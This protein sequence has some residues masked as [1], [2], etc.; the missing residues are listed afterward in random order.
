M[1]AEGHRS[2]VGYRAFCEMEIGACRCL[3]PEQHHQRGPGETVDVGTVL[4]AAMSFAEEI[5]HC[6]QDNSS[7]LDGD[8]VFGF[9]HL[10]VGD[11]SLKCRRRLELRFRTPRT[12][13]VGIIRTCTKI[14]PA[15]CIVKA[16][17]YCVL[18]F[19]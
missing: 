3:H 11:V 13:P 14:C 6:A 18:D 17:S 9:D 5:E 1:A 2:E 16:V 7:A 4:V 19:H 12:I 8:V 10:D 15:M